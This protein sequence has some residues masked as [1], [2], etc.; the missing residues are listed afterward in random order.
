[1]LPAL[2]YQRRY[3]GWFG[4]QWAIPYAFFWLFCLSWISLWGLVT[5][6]ISGW[7]T[8]ETAKVAQQPKLPTVPQPAMVHNVFSKA[9]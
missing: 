2:V 9:A 6:P 4:W 1:V 8:R 3:G 7:L 5:A